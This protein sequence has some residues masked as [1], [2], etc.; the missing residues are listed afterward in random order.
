MGDVSL[1]NFDGGVEIAEDVSKV[2]IIGGREGLVRIDDPVDE[3][4]LEDSL[5][6]TLDQHIDQILFLW[7]FRVEL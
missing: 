6:K 3:L 1:C 5:V 4:L 7:L 2:F